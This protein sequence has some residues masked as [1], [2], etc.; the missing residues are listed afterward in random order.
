MR[1]IKTGG[2]D[3]EINQELF[4]YQVTYAV[5]YWA[6]YVLS[7]VIIPV[8]QEYERAG[9]FTPKARLKRAIRT[10]VI[11][12]LIFLVVGVVF[13]LY[14]IIKQQLTGYRLIYFLI[15]LSNAWG[16]FLIIFMLGYG[17]VAV[18]K[19]IIQLSDYNTRVK[20]LEYCAGESKEHLE[21]TNI[22]LINC[23]QVN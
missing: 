1:N 11:M 2:K 19:H 6:I 22:D 23:A 21:E 3:P 14:L 17:L 18:P 5:I 12:Y 15:A 13:I 4:V 16:I 10:N 9:D 20:Y 8:A 7:W